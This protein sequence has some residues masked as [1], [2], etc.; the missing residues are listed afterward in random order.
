[1]KTRAALLAMTA[2]AVLVASPAAAQLSPQAK[3]VYADFERLGPNR[4]FMLSAKG[5]GFLWA[6]ATGG[7]PGGAVERG[8]KY[9]E[10]QSKSACTLHTVNNIPLDGRDW[11]T[12]A[13]PALPNIGRLRPQPWW[14]N[15]GPQAAAGLQG[16]IHQHRVGLGLGNHLDGGGF[17]GRFADDV[18]A[19][20]GAELMN[21]LVSKGGGT[22]DNDNIHDATP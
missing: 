15:R 8:L 11:K 13:P 19:L 16:Q 9:C 10:E 4:A 2:A 5:E 22:F 1:M 6:G 7:D 17:I 3:K 21:Q 20:V 14:Q 18:H 12:V